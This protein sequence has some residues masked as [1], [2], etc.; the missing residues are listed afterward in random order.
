MAVDIHFDHPIFEGGTYG[1]DVEMGLSASTPTAYIE[2]TDPYLNAQ[3]RGGVL[4]TNSEGVA[5]IGGYCKTDSTSPAGFCFGVT[6]SH[7]QRNSVS[8]MRM[9]V[10]QG[11]TNT[12]LP[13]DLNS[14]AFENVVEGNIINGI[15]S[16]IFNTGINLASSTNNTITGN[17]LNG[18]GTT[19]ISF[20]A[21]STGNKV[22]QNIVDNTNISTTYSDSTTAGNFYCSVTAVPPAN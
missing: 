21:S 20:D 19:G 6:G 10:A 13:V 16:E 2:I 14:G 15:S 7:S 9:N 11:T 4:I 12:A 17:Q 8:K 18:Y 1:F 22:C 5:V 3:S